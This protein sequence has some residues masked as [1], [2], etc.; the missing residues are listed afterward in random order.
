MAELELRLGQRSQ[1]PRPLRLVPLLGTGG[2]RG[3]WEEGEDVREGQ[4]HMEGVG[5]G[6]RNRDFTVADISGSEILTSQI[7]RS[8]ILRSSLAD[9]LAEKE[10]ERG[11]GKHE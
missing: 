9:R 2:G 6:R 10:R 1:L 5:C 11:R 7:S 8:E 4:D 3:T